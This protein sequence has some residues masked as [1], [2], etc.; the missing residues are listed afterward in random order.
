MSQHEEGQ[1]QA[2]TEEGDEDRGQLVPV[3]QAEREVLKRK[4]IQ[5]CEPIFFVLERPRPLYNMAF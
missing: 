1:S 3:V 5:H 2:G 4:K